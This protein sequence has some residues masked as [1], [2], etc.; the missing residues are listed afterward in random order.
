MA[1]MTTKDEKQLRLHPLIRGL[2]EAETNEDRATLAKLR[3]GLGK[4]VGE[5]GAAERD[6]WVLQRL[7]PDVGRSALDRCCL[8]ASLFGLH[9][10]PFKSDA[11]SLK[12]HTLGT[13]FRQLDEKLNGQRTQKK[14]RKRKGP[15]RRFVA[16]LDSDPADLPLRLRHAVSLFKGNDIS[17][18]YQRLLRDLRNWSHPERFVQR[19]WASDFW[20]RNPQREA[21]D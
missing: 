5:P 9:P 8:V 15:E 7:P 1:T 4:N 14:E 20:G 21:E 13:S 2:Q 17:I 11:K 16:L 6:G 12:K 10:L 18:N 19:R 3:R